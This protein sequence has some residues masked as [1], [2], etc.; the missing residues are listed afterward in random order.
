M[1]RESTPCSPLT[2]AGIRGPAFEPG[3]CTEPLAGV[4]EEHTPIGFVQG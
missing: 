4:G 3:E 1:C 2:P